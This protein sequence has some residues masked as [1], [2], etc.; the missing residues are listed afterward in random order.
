MLLVV[1]ED[2]EHDGL[3]LDVF[4]EGLGHL[5]GDLSAVVKRGESQR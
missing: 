5:H 4:Y 3:A 1:A 2:L